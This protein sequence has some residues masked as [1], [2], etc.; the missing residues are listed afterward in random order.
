MEEKKQLV[1]NLISQVA[2][3]AS[4]AIIS[5]V[6]T[7]F[8]LDKLG[9]EAYGFIGLVTNFVSY[10]AIVTTSLNSMAG[11][12]VAVAYHGGQKKEATQYYT[13]TFICN[14]MFAMLSILLSIVLAAHI[15]GLVNVEEGLVSDLRITIIIAFL[16][17]SVSLIGVVFGLASF[18]TNKL[19]FSS[20]AQLIG[21][22]LRVVVL[23]SLF[24]FLK[25]H[26]WYYS[27]AAL[28]STATVLF[29]NI[30]VAKA[31]L[32][33]I[34][35]R[36]NAFSG[37]RLFEIMKEGAWV[38]LQGV[39][40]MLQT[41]LDL[42][43]ANLFVGGYGM[44]LLSVARTIPLAL[45][46]FSGSIA[47]L[48][49]P[50]MAEEYARNGVSERLQG[51]FLLAMRF[52]LLIMAVPLIGLIV[53]GETF[54]SLWLSDQDGSY[55]RY[56]QALSFLTVISLL[57]SALIEPL[58]YADYLLR[59]LKISTLITLGFSILAVVVELVLLVFSPLDK[60]CVIAGTSSCFVF[61]RHAVV[62]PL[63]CSYITGIRKRVFFAPLAREIIALC[64]L[65]LVYAAISA[66]VPVDSWLMFVAICA[67]SVF[68][69]YPLLAVILFRP[70]E[71]VSLALP[72][73]LVGRIKKG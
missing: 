52:T 50:K 44:G 16:N 5:F 19:Y 71:L 64:S 68:V 2:V 40:R 39:N 41:G 30:G 25:P 20:I 73:K 42:L 15:A 45:Y 8:V 34:Q 18:V 53:Y 49:Y 57:G 56:V 33:A 36:L 67:L 72:K 47:N 63:Y 48:F 7:P 21:S 60:L 29:M 14:C 69:G 65:A 24:L 32:P 11:R 38:S 13:S 31:I 66:L 3:I 59:K 58:Y 23:C 1:I 4:Q 43:I 9:E 62:Q 51:R 35:I 6:L 55:V 26:M 46:S 54:Y 10:T 61:V 37:R 12:F 22:L 70:S 28:V 17:A 27:V